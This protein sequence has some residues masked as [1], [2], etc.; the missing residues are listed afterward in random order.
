MKLP[1]FLRIDPDFK[2]AVDVY[3]DKPEISFCGYNDDIIFRDFK[4][5]IVGIYREA[6]WAERR[7]A[8]KARNKAKRVQVRIRTA[9]SSERNRVHNRN[10][11]RKLMGE[12]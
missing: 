5:E 9:I 2:R 7:Y 3:P 10:P 8:R 12:K 11:L 6:T 4:N 1:R